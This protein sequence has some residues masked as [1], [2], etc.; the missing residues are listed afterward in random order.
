MPVIIPSTTRVVVSNSFCGLFAMQVCAV[1]D[2]TDEEILAVA[3]R[4]NLCGTTNG[5]C[6]VIRKID[7]EHDWI[8]EKHLPKQCEDNPDRMHFLVGC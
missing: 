1:K 2:A 8:Q 6:Y 7:P 5:W 4:D 3:N